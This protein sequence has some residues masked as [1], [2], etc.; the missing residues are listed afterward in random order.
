MYIWDSSNINYLLLLDLTLQHAPSA[1]TLASN[2]AN[3]SGVY[4]INLILYYKAR[5]GHLYAPV[6]SPIFPLTLT[7]IFITYFVTNIITQ[8]DYVSHRLY[9]P[10]VIFRI[11]T[12]PFSAVSLR[13][14]YT[15][16]VMTSFIKVFSN[17]I[18]AM[19]YLASESYSDRDASLHQFGQCQHGYMFYITAV[20]AVLPLWFRFAQCLRRISEVSSTGT[21][22]RFK[23]LIWPH[24]YNALKY[25]LALIVVL[26]GV[27]RPVSSDAGGYKYAFIAICMITT[28]YQFYWD[29]FMDWGLMQIIPSPK[30]FS[31]EGNLFLRKKLL[32]KRK[33]YL[34]YIAMCVD[35]LLRA[36]WTLSLIPQGS[37]SGPFSYSISD[38]LG[39]FLAMFELFRRTMWGCYR[40]ESEHINAST[41]AE[42]QDVHPPYHVDRK[43]SPVDPNKDIKIVAYHVIAGGL[44]LLTFVLL[45]VN[46]G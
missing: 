25:L 39:P 23:F 18:Y 44:A 28:A 14:T 46:I 6:P 40:L 16:D 45:I 2:T 24:S 20:S 17:G 8:R 34:Y 9:S 26:M 12:S 42:S 30:D 11:V 33:I 5:R 43:P 22:I 4:I 27:L 10:Q 13:E 37:R 36:L 29:I 19:C 38:Q 7:L 21:S 15:A 3:L 1:V 35:L 41:G 31:F 32:F